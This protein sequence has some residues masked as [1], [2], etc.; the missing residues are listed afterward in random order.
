MKLHHIG[1]LVS[2]IE[3]SK[4]AFSALGFSLYKE[5]IFDE[6]RK[7]DICFMKKDSTLVEL[8]SGGGGDE[9]I[10]SNLYKRYKN[11]PYHLCFESENFEEDM[12]H[13]QESRF[14]QMEEPAPAPA[15][16]G[17]KVCYFMSPAIGM[18][19]LLSNSLS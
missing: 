19:E 12:S 4:K 1:Y 7:C 6:Q 8:V 14:V 15:I 5:T 2:N 11:S 9:S 10:V 3:R 17:K 13:L 18:V 16:E